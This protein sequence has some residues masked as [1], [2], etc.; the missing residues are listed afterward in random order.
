MFLELPTEIQH[1]IYD[2]LV[3]DD[4][5]ALN[6]A[7]PKKKRIVQ[8]INTCKQ[9]DKRLYIIKQVFKKH[10]VSAEDIS[11]KLYDFLCENRD[12]PSIQCILDENTELKL[13]SINNNVNSLSFILWKVGK[14]KDV[15]VEVEKATELTPKDFKKILEIA[16]KH[17]SPT[18]WDNLIGL[19]KMKQ[20][21][22]TMQVDSG[23]IFNMINYENMELLKHVVSIQHEHDFLQHSLEDMRRP[24]YVSCFY[25]PRSIHMLL[26]Y[27]HIP[28]SV[29][30]EMVKEH[31]LNGKFE[32]AEVY[33]KHMMS[34]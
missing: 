1:T 14:Q 10:K 6:K 22:A 12:D 27:V 5:I 2:K 34:C 19:E 25:L 16:A 13:K 8:T 7:L 11:G 29:Q 24:F 4:R 15:C 20:A 31:A 3:I 33:L 21:L 18:Y 28:V 30:E 32:A 9:K 23:L 26:D 17:C